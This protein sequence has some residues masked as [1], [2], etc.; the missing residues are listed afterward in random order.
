MPIDCCRSAQQA[1]EEF[2]RAVGG[3]GRCPIRIDLNELKLLAPVDGRV[4]ER[5]AVQKHA[6]RS[7]ARHPI[8]RGRY[9]HDVGAGGD[10]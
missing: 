9:E 6:W 10:S 1:L 2:A 5:Q 4:V 8:C 7:M 3:N